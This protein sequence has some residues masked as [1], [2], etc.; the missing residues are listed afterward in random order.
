[1][2]V[3]HFASCVTLAKLFQFFVPQFPHLK[4]EDNNICIKLQ[5]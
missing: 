5:F 3:W 1:M 2:G 4:N